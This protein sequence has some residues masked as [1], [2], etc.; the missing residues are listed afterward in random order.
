M[1]II[2]QQING[3]ADSKWNGIIGSVYKMIGIDIHSEP[4]LTK[5][6]QKLE[7]ESTGTNADE[8]CR[9]ALAA[10][11]GYSFWFSY[12]SGKIWA[13]NG[14]TWTLAY[15]TVP[16]AGGAGTLG[17]MEYNGFIYWATES[18]LY[19]VTIA[20]ADDSWA[21]GAVNGGVTTGWQTFGVTDSEWHPM[22]LQ[23]LSLFI[24][25]GNQV[26]SVDD[27]GTFDDNALDIKTP[28]RIK[29]M[30]DFEIDLLIG[31]FVDNNVS[32]TEIIRW[33]TESTS[34]NTLDPIEEVGINAFIRD[35]NFVYAQAGLAGNIY[36]FNG[37]TL[38]PFNKIPGEYSNTKYGEVH[39]GSHANFQG[40]PIF[41]FSNG[42]G[43]PAEQGV[44][45]L[46][47][48]S[49]NY[50]KV[51]D[52]SW[53]NSQDKTAS[54][55]IGAIV[56]KNSEVMVAWKDSSS[57]GVD[58]LDNSNKYASASI[59]T[60]MLF[61]DK[62]DQ[63]N[64]L[65]EVEAFYHSLPASTGLTFSYDINNAGYVAMTSV[66]DTEKNRIYSERGGAEFGSLKIKVAFTTNNN[67]APE[68]EA[69]GV[70]ID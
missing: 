34:W 52:L 30:I 44:Y 29:S 18:R 26:A 7:V 64:T 46:G 32:R 31:T 48:Y 19:R 16:G 59:E 62:R 66:D 33:D 1:A 10:S 42:S 49:R 69:I 67:D 5:V 11:N 17:A 60:R 37:R 57:F 20:G 63:Q 12:T 27:S 22:A 23:N 41:G 15:T 3:L 43:N 45:T 38:E 50:P 65:R 6:Q 58:R 8:F 54:Q 21:A 68:I 56:V 4:G 39:P 36:F 55:E 24:G 9:V 47:S 51:L 2:L 35:D 14:G 40:R 28:L 13:E 61:Q 70:N 25:D 53:V